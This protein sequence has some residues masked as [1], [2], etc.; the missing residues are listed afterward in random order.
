MLFENFDLG[1]CQVSFLNLL[2]TTLYY[3]LNVRISKG[4]YTLIKNSYKTINWI[5]ILKFYFHC[6]KDLCSGMELF[7]RCKICLQRVPHK[8]SKPCFSFWTPSWHSSIHHRTR[9]QRGL[10]YNQ[11]TACLE[12]LSMARV[13]LSTTETS[14]WKEQT[15]MLASGENRTQLTYFTTQYKLLPSWVEP[16]Y[17]QTG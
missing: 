14:V 12:V 4:C 1:K 17:I 15:S 13:N 9:T 11:W 7:K 5:I 16:D 10:V 8:I 2:L 6:W 3:L